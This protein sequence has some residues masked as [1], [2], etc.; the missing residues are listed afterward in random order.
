PGRREVANTVGV[1]HR[2][3]LQ[4]LT[5]CPD[6]VD[7]ARFTGAGVDAVVVDDVPGTVAALK[8]DGPR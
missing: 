6:P 7:A 3:G 4:V 2:A 5:W 8:A 1:A